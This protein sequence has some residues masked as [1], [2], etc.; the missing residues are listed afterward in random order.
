[1]TALQAQSP[2]LDQDSTLVS[3]Y[4][5]AEFAK[6]VEYKGESD[7]LI[8]R[9]NKDITR[10]EIVNDEQAKAIFEYENVQ[11]PNLKNQI[12]LVNTKFDS[13]SEI[14]A[15]K[16]DIHKS[17]IKRLRRAKLNWGIGGAVLG[18]IAISLASL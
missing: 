13:Q 8:D 3:Y 16:D 6:F 9:M 1:M 15:I 14:L 18:I 12:S 5:L 7:T 2:I 10:L 4:R 11:I 17:E